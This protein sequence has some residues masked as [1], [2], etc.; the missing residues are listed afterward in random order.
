MNKIYVKKGLYHLQLNT[1]AALVPTLPSTTQ[2]NLTMVSRT[3]A[4]ERNIMVAESPDGAL[5]APPNTTV[6]DLPGTAVIEPPDV[7]SDAEEYVYRTPKRGPNT[8]PN[9]T[10]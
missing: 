10:A 4:T 6:I 8:P 3:E 5:F 1:N 2:Q 7:P 9:G